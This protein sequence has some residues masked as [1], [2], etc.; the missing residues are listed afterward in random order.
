[1]E[2][3]PTEVGAEKSGELAPTDVGVRVSTVN[4]YVVGGVDTRPPPDWFVGR[5][6]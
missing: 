2:L 4:D 1:M 5:A 3:A 6:L